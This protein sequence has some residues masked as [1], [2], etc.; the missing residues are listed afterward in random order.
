MKKK[1][2]SVLLLMVIV[3]ML[4]PAVSALPQKEEEMDQSTPFGTGNYFCGMNNKLV[5]QAFKP[6][7][8]VLSK[9][10]L[11][12]FKMENITGNFTISIRQRLNGEDLVSKT[13]SIE[14]VP[15]KSYGD[16]VTIDLEDINVTPNKRYYIVF[17]SDDARVILWVMSSYN[18]YWRG[19]PWMFGGSIPFWIPV[20]LSVTKIPDMSFRTY[21]YSS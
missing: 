9:V 17:T 8:P 1:I 11:G 5:A 19:R 10:E 16:W 6:K 13:V 12:M 3:G 20:F 4:I 2:R 18:P 21:G 14:E 15:W 7:L